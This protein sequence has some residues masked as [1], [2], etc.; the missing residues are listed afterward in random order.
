MY[1]KE[2]L[3]QGQDRKHN[4]KQFKSDRI[5]RKRKVRSLFFVADQGIKNALRRRTL[6]AENVQSTFIFT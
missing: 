1:R 2:K 6:A 3:L 4:K 5:F